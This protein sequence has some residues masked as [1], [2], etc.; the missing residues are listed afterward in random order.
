MS[1]CDALLWAPWAGDCPSPGIVSTLPAAARPTL[2]SAPAFSRSLRVMDWSTRS[3]FRDI[4]PLRLVSACSLPFKAFYSG[5]RL[6]NW[7]REHRAARVPAPD[8]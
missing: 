7:I 3:F 1:W 2:P 6:R 8:R 5:S 4:S